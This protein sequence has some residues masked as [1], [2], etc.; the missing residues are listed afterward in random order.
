MGDG[1]DAA[2]EVDQQALQPL[3]RV[4]V[5]VV[6]GFVEQQHVGLRHQSLGQRDALFGAA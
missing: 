6:G 2:F 3:D 5:Q 4:Q 1:D